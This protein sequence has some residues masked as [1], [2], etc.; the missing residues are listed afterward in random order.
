MLCIEALRVARERGAL[1]PTARAQTPR[2]REGGGRVS[3]RPLSKG[4][5]K[6]YRKTGNAYAYLRPYLF[7]ILRVS[8][9]PLSPRARE[10]G[11]G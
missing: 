2:A 8:E 10:E 11:G 7:M 9:R 1:L 4:A 3:E 6:V 5:F